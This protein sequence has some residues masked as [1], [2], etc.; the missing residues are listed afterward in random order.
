M[1]ANNKP[2]IKSIND[3][4]GE[5]D[6]VLIKNDR[7]YSVGKHNGTFIEII[8]PIVEI[9]KC[10]IELELDKKKAEEEEKIK[11]LEITLATKT[12]K[13]KELELTRIKREKYF[14]KFKKRFNISEDMAMD[15]LFREEETAS[16]MLDFY[17]D[18]MEGIEEDDDAESFDDEIEDDE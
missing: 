6:M 14:D 17:I 3:N 2:K 13:E 10:K 9:P 16:E 1:V 12:E 7:E 15:T 4:Y 11:N 5:G 18:Q 8:R